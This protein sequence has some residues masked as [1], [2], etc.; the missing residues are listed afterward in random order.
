MYAF[1]LLRCCF[2]FVVFVCMMFLLRILFCGI[3]VFCKWLFA[4]FR[5]H[6]AFREA[7]VFIAQCGVA[8]AV[9]AL[10]SIAIAY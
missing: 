5:V 2:D 6:V 3:C 1:Y 4:H 7:A 9:I 10:L 8:R